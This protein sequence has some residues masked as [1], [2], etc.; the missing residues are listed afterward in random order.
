[1]KRKIALIEEDKV[2]SEDNE[3]AETFMSYFETKS[4]F[5]WEKKNYFETILENLGIDSK[6]MSMDPAS[7]DSETNI[8]KKFENHPFMKKKKK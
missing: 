8:G 5:P 4:C 6:Y 2:A 1:M 3:V 7:D